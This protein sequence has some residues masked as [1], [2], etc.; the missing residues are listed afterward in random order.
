MVIYSSVLHWKKGI[1]HAQKIC[2][3][4]P[5]KFDDGFSRLYFPSFGNSHGQPNPYDCCAHL[6]TPDCPAPYKHT[7][8]NELNPDRFDS[9]FS[10]IVCR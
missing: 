3:S 8:S 7:G 6:A 4:V 9:L 1:R 5:A 2:V 10:G